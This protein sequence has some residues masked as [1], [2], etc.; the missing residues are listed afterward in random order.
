MSKSE[1]TIFCYTIK[2]KCHSC[3][4]IGNKAS[5]CKSRKMKDDVIC[6][7]YKK[8]GHVKAKCIKFSQKNQVKGEVKSSGIR[9]NVADGEAVVVLCSMEKDC[10]SH[11]IWIGDSGAS[12]HFCNNDDGLFDDT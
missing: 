9:N 10:F 11:E 1:V 12:C 3:G 8:L 7:Y 4:K 5:K 6:S 2:G